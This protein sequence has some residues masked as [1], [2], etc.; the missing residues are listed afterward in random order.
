VV[1]RPAVRVVA[2]RLAAATLPAET[3]DPPVVV[4]GPRLVVKALA[5]M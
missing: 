3:M 2:T 5:S 1:L 4:H